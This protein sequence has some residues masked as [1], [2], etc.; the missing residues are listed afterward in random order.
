MSISFPT[1]ALRGVCARVVAGYE[2]SPFVSKLTLGGSIAAGRGDQWSDLDVTAFT[3]PQYQGLCWERRGNDL[4]RCGDLL[5]LA[6][7]TDLAPDS[8]VGFFSSV[9]R[10]HVTY[11]VL[12]EREE[13]EGGEEA[14]LFENLEDAIPP[15]PASAADSLPASISDPFALPRLAFWCSRLMVG[16]RRGDVAQTAEARLR[17]LEIVLA[18][19]AGSRGASHSSACV[20]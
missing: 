1:D 15:H 19:V 8:T 9:L 7:I 18:R 5:A 16:V 6:D 20:S 14:L 2:A 12:A 4:A 3:E 11:K 10:V 17:M 13:S